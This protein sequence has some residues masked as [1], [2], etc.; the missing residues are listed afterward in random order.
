MNNKKFIIFLV[1]AALIVGG[2]FLFIKIYNHA[3]L[4]PDSEAQQILSELVPKAEKINEI[5]WGKGLPVAE[6]QD[7][8]LDSVTAAQYRLVSEDSPYK[9][10]EELRKAIAEVYSEKYIEKTIEYTAFKG[11]EGAIEESVSSQMYPRYKDNDAG[12]LLIDITNP[13]WELNTV[14]DTSTAKAVDAERDKQTIEVKATVLGEETTL[15]LVIVEQEEGWR[16]DT[17]TY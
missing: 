12:S 13:G 5:I 4:I 3:E 14:I 8:A 6:G 11:A 9:N 10:T 1:V 15:T 17:P 2:I 7:P 16:L